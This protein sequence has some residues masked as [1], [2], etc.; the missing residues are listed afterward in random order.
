[1]SRSAGARTLPK[2]VA[3]LAAAVLC[4]ASPP[5]LAWATPVTYDIA[6]EFFNNVTSMQYAGGFSGSFTIDTSALDCG[7]SGSLLSWD[8]SVTSDP[9]STLSAYH[10]T[11]GVPNAF[12]QA[13][14]DCGLTRILVA[15]TSTERGF[16]FNVVLVEA[17]E[18][19]NGGV[20]EVPYLGTS[21]FDPPTPGVVSRFVG[22]S[23]IWRVPEPNSSV[24]VL[25]SLIALLASRRPT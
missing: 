20:E 19:F 5:M 15:D 24:L 7:D 3:R 8:I 16:G 1:M 17:P 18:Y 6:G 14:Q 10:Y 11:S 9:T 21:P 23:H 13:T 25:A 22:V 2:V 12:S 4:T